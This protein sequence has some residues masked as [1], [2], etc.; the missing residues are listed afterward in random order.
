MVV[1]S[2]GSGAGGD[3][4]GEGEWWGRY[5]CAGGNGAGEGSESGSLVSQ[6]V[7]TFARLRD[8]RGG[9]GGFGGSR[10]VR[11]ACRIQL[12]SSY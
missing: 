5:A 9:D 3:D 6:T 2:A 8:F 12:I 11:L 1:S 4:A 7:T 10:S